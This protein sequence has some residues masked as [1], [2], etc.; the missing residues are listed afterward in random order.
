M[1]GGDQS[2]S[3][4]QHERT[5]GQRAAGGCRNTGGPREP[6][7]NV[8]CAVTDLHAGLH[9]PKAFLKGKISTERIFS[10]NEQERIVCR[11]IPNNL[12][13]RPISSS[14]NEIPTKRRGGYVNKDPF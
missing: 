12:G 13:K 14:Y 7:R 5:H 9:P 10:F 4:Q 3:Y 8:K 1:R 11:Q 6:P 2:E